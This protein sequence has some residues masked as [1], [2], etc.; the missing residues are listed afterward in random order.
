MRSILMPLAALLFLFQFT[1][2]ALAGTDDGYGGGNGTKCVVVDGG[3]VV[4][5]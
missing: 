4:C 3:L 2:S 5:R 1:A